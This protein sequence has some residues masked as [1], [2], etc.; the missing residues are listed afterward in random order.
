[1]QSPI[2]K[3]KRTTFRGARARVNVSNRACVCLDSSL[4]VKMSQSFFF[5]KSL[6]QERAE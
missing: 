1:M 6:K 4:R 3:K 5:F 2:K